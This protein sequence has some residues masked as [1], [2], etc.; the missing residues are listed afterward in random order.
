MTDLKII[1]KEL[2]AS[3]FLEKEQWSLLLDDIELLR[4]YKNS[5]DSDEYRQYLNV[6]KIVDNDPID[7][8]I[9]ENKPILEYGY[10]KFHKQR[11]CLFCKRNFVLKQ[12]Y[13]NYYCERL[14][15]PPS[16]QSKV[17]FVHSD[18]TFP[19][20]NFSFRIEL[21]WLIYFDLKLP[22]KMDIYKIFLNPS[23][24]E[25]KPGL[26]RVIFP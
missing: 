16:F 12:D 21:I 24:Y 5:K 6:L 25:P 13:L 1:D 3:K 9:T 14:I 22:D 17:N 15:G 20:N 18:E 8:K 7:T 11:T 26:K 4:K 23:Y 10:E 2:R 19:S